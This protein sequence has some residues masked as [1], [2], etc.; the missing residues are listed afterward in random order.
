M[1]NPEA[2]FNIQVSLLITKTKNE[3]SSH[4]FCSKHYKLKSDQLFNS[5]IL[6]LNQNSILGRRNFPKCPLQF[7]VPEIGILHHIT[8]IIIN[9]VSR[10]DEFSSYSTSDT[11]LNS[12]ALAAIGEQCRTVPL[13]TKYQFYWLTV[14]PV[15]YLQ[16]DSL[17]CCRKAAKQRNL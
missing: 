6:A 2:F 1:C 4:I 5:S 9:K 3:G 7:L 11:I 17:F 10:K 13:I 14:I 12:S 8:C 16:Q 15:Q